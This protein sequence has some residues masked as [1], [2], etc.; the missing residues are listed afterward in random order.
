MDMF[1]KVYDKELGEV[2]ISDD[3]IAVC[4]VNAAVRTPGVASL[5]GGIMDNLSKDILGKE[6]ISKGV[7]V[8]QSD[9]GIGVD[10]FINVKYGVPIP[11]VAWDIQENVKAE[12]ENMTEKD[13]LFVN[14]HVQGVEVE[15]TGSKDR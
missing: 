3:V 5:S 4:A 2:K 14:I 15:D 12:I 8:N 7:K 11:E 10:V 1:E 9:E 13:V 6:S